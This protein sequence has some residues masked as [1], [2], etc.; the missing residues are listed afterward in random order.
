MTN[1]ET[2]KR[3]VLRMLNEEYPE[4]KDV[5]IVSYD[6]EGKYYYTIFLGIKPEDSEKLDVIKIRRS[7]RELFDYV[8]PH[9]TL[10]N[11]N[12]FNPEPSYY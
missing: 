8:Y 4:L 1:N 2:L 5:K 10:N 3:I 11:I 12:F 6:D 7:V 9:D